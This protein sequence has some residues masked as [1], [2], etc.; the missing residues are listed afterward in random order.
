ME[1]AKL[2]EFSL[3]SSRSFHHTTTNVASILILRHT[4][5]GNSLLAPQNRPSQGTQIVKEMALSTS[6]WNLLEHMKCPEIQAA[7]LNLALL[8]MQNY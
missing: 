6:F 1:N 7:G 2:L 5:E 8:S 4:L 3:L